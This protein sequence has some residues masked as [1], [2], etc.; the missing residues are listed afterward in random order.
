MYLYE[1][2]PARA[3]SLSLR[4]PSHC[5]GPLLSTQSNDDDA[6]IEAKLWLRHTHYRI[7]YFFSTHL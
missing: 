1:H 3:A 7:R 5:P 6:Y 4:R 2:I